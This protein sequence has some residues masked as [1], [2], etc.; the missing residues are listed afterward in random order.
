M[1]ASI[2]D[3]KGVGSPLE[4]LLPRL[5]RVTDRGDGRYRASCPTSVHL[6]GDRSRGLFITE[7][8]N[9]SILIKCF[10]GCDIHS[11]VSAVSLELSDLFPNTGNENGTPIKQQL[12]PREVLNVARDEL[13]VVICGLERLLRGGELTDEDLER[14]RTTMYRLRGVLEVSG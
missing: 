14:L 7:N 9:K 2:V 6:H 12:S 13:Y 5:D 3:K 1:N 10:A 8:D 4:F 11:I